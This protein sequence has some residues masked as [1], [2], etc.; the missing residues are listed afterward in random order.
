MGTRGIQEVFG[1][2]KRLQDNR[3]SWLRSAVFS[4]H[5]NYPIRVLYP[6]S[7]YWQIVKGVPQAE[8]LVFADNSRLVLDRSK[9]EGEKSLSMSVMNDFS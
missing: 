3:L 6:S 4:V 2:P 8:A 1:E 9:I 5:E 7:C